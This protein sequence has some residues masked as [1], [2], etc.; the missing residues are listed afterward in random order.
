[1][2]CRRD[3]ELY[4]LEH[5]FFFWDTVAFLANVTQYTAAP[6]T[7]TPT[8]AHHYNNRGYRTHW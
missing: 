7:A 8:L 4:R 6:K 3:I 5:V 2:L 1:M